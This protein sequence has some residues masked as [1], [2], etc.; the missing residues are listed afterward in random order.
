MRENE[1]LSVE[2]LEVKY[3]L[4]RST[5]KAVNGVS[6]T[7]NKGERVGLVGETGAGKTT[8]AL[9]ILRLIP[10]PPGKITNGTI[11]LNGRNLMETSEK[12]MRKIRGNDVSMIFQDPMTSLSPVMTVGDQI[13]EVISLHSDMSKAQTIE[14]AKEMLELVG[15]PGERYGEYPHQFSGGMRQRVLIAISLACNPKLLIADEPTS[16]LDVTIQAQVLELIAD[17][18]KKFNMSLLLITHDLGVVA[19]TCDRI[20]IMYSGRIVES[21]PV[22]TV[23]KNI[24]HPYTVGLFNSLPRLDIDTDRLEPIK[25]MMPDPNDLPPGCTF[26]DRCPYVMER[27]KQELPV[28]SEVGEGHFVACFH[29]CN[30]ESSNG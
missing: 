2:N 1:L 8:T 12:D 13:R 15:I 28:L 7:I 25:G 29:A 5:V 11:T 26:Y 17:L 19:E 20:M 27:C 21:G 16:A 24:Q 23:Y 30:K 3:F 18:R 10:E 22:R 6:F 14:R 9:S 4:R